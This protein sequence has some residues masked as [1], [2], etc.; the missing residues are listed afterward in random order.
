M[1][2]T[3]IPIAICGFLRTD[4]HWNQALALA[5]IAHESARTA[6]DRQGQAWA[7][8]EL[9]TTQELIAEYQAATVSQSQALKLYRAL[10]D[11]HGQA[12]T[13]NHLGMLH[14]LSGDCRKA[15][16]CL[17][18]A[19][20]LVRDLGD[21]YG[22]AEVL[23]NLG[24]LQCPSTRNAQSDYARA[25]TIAEEIEAPLQIARALEGI[26]RYQVQKGIHTQGFGYLRRALEIYRDLGTPDVAS[27]EIFCSPKSEDKRDAL[28]G[29]LSGGL[30][31]TLLPWPGVLTC[32]IPRVR[33]RSSGCRELSRHS[34]AVEHPGRSRR[35]Q[36]NRR[37]VATFCGD[38][39][40]TDGQRETSP[41][42]RPAHA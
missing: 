9:G 36:S 3:R 21:R 25:L 17:T 32:R 29:G 8:S 2:A 4:G 34:A 1:H 10:G 5:K 28:D 16:S 27:L 41:H 35:N 22:Q 20:K 40:D 37:P 15:F 38:G 26:G 33:R 19:L 18:S 23:N 6:E 14:E 7:L 30:K 31:R 11:K 12:S 39:D 24:Q 13:L 42:I